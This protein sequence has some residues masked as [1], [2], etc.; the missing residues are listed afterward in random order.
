MA[1]FTRPAPAPETWTPEGTLISQRYRALEG[2]TVLVYTADADRGAARYAAACRAMPR[3]IPARPTDAAAAKQ[4]YTRLWARRYGTAPHQ[5]HIADFHTLR[6]DLQ[7]PTD[8][9]KT[10][11][12]SIAQTDPGFLTATPTSYGQGTRFTV[13]PF[14]RP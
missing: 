1:L 4:I 3:G 7:R 11:L 13:Q 6:I 10:L 5:V 2:A 9:I 8:W 12:T 14:D